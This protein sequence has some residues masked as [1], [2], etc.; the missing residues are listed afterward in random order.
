MTIQVTAAQVEALEAINGQ[1]RAAAAVV[2]ATTVQPNQQVKVPAL[3]LEATTVQPNQPARVHGAQFESLQQEY[4]NRVRVHGA[5]YEV[6][7]PLPESQTSV[8]VAGVTIEVLR[9]I[10]DKKRR[11]PMNVVAN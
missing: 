11:P 3:Q 5:Q 7:Y 8:G 4:P 9:S 6:L 1:I 2:E 10:E